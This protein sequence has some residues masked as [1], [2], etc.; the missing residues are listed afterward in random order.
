MGRAEV[1]RGTVRAEH[2]KRPLES[3]GFAVHE[4]LS[5]PLVTDLD[6]RR[7]RSSGRIDGI[8]RK[9]V[10][11]STAAPVGSD[12][13]RAPESAPG[14]ATAIRCSGLIKHYG[15]VTAVDGLDLEVQ[16]GECFGLLGPNGAGKTTT[17]EILEGLTPA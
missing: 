16:L 8:E 1:F 12:G 4:V 13:S 5:R 14:V 15:D 11:S 7:S 6:F 2:G 3:E 10:M 17:I 9:T